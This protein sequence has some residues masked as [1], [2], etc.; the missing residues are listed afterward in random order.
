MNA[1]TTTAMCAE[2]GHPIDGTDDGR[3]GPDTVDR[4]FCGRVSY[5]NDFGRMMQ[6]RNGGRMYRV[7]Y[8][9]H[10]REDQVDFHCLEDVTIFIEWGRATGAFVDA[11]YVSYSD[12]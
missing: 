11:E 6:D 10:G 5:L 9:M 12:K 8:V 7:V 1:P 3:F 2:A 4:C